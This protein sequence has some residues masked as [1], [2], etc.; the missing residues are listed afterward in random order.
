MMRVRSA[1][2][3]EVLVVEPVAFG[4]A[5]GLFAETWNAA[6]YAA[7]GV[8][9]TF[10]QDNMSRSRQGVLRGLH[11]QEPH[12]QGKLISVLH[13]E[14]WDVAVDV[15]R[16]SPRFG[17]WFGTR[18]SAD[19]LRQLWI[20]PGFAHGFLVLSEEAVLSYKVTAPHHPEAELTVAW[21]DPALGIEWPLT[22]SPLLSPRDAAAPRLA[23]IDPER[24]PR[25][26]DG[27]AVMSRVAE[28][29]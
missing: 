8:D 22:R 2:L 25:V 19:P 13:G 23:D 16:D 10:V 5:R 3:P 1:D 7:H 21:N 20:P 29:A 4:D 12:G 26:A 15:R 18:L 6:R 11:L 28:P 27:G 9:A 14:V 24:L 17:R